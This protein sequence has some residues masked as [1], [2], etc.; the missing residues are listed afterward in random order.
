LLPTLDI[1][2]ES[3]KYY[4]SLVGYY[5]VHRLKQLNEWG[6]Y[7]YLL[8]FAYHRY[9]R[10]HD[11]LIRCLIYNTRRFYDEAKA[12]A[13]ERIYELR[14]ENNQNLRKAGRVLKLFTDEEI[15]ENTPFETVQSRAFAILERNKLA[16][17]ADQIAAHAPFDETALRWQE[18]DRLARQFKLHL[19]PIVQSIELEA[20][21]AQAPLI[22]ALQVLKTTFA[23]GKPLGKTRD[24]ALPVQFIPK[25]LQRYLYGP[26]ASDSVL[27]SPKFLVD[28]YEFFVYRQLCHGLEAGDIFCR[29]SVGFR[30]LEDDLVG[31]EQWQ[32]K[33]KL[34]N[35]SPQITGCGWQGYLN[36]AGYAIP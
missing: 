15:A 24:D 30:S 7:L 32:D 35:C 13:K 34:R 28:R 9:Q 3:V 12:L 11:N 1:S 23:K 19:R 29:D 25:T 16:L 27:G 4:A 2:N 17:V 21:S 8:C 33:N 31:N 20:I 22:K 18:I 10:L 36:T 14:I 26:S 6:V 5:S